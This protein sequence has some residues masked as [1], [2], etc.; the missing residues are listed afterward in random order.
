MRSDYFLS[1]ILFVLMIFFLSLAAINNSNIHGNAVIL[2]VSSNVS[3]T[4]SLAVSFSSDLADG[5]HFGN[6]NFLPAT[7]V[8]AS[9]NYNGS[10][11]A[12]LYF[13]EVSSDGNTPVDLCLRAGSDLVSTGA[14]RLGY[15]NE[16][17]SSFVGISNET[18]P[19]VS[20]ENPMSL[21]STLVESSVP[22]GERIYLRFWLDV[23]SGQASGSYNN[24]I[25]FNGIGEGIGC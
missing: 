8:N 24:S 4:K 3:I 22:L 9:E 2:D 5:I 7:N 11:N 21:V 14:D 18:S 10:L 16:S 17:Y 1:V 20:F 19:D 13:V 25:Y 12:T 6:V 23:P 15:N